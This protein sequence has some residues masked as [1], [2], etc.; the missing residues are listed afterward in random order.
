M[1]RNPAT[2]A[3][4]GPWKLTAHGA[5]FV[6]E[7]ENGDLVGTGDQALPNR[8]YAHGD[9]RA[10]AAVH[11]RIERDHSSRDSAWVIA[12]V[13]AKTVASTKA[14]SDFHMS[15]PCGCRGHVRLNIARPPGRPSTLGTPW[16][17]N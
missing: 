3:A 17:A 2:D 16:R 10:E 4:A 6:V 1:G 14:N 11:P 5:F 9:E 7:V 15:A 13:V 12:T 8:S